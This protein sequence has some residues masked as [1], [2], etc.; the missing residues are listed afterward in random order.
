MAFLKGPPHNVFHRWRPGFIDA[1][2]LA[3]CPNDNDSNF[4]LGKYKRFWFNRMLEPVDEQVVIDFFRRWA[5]SQYL[6][7][8][9]LTC[10][11]KYALRSPGECHRTFELIFAKK[12]NGGMYL[13][14]CRQLLGR[15]REPVFGH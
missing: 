4:K 14:E 10:G 5:V 11:R 1:H 3:N 6:K 13:S 9:W 15:F 2:E 12:I 8:M 7:E